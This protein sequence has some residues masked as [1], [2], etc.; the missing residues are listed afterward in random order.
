[1]E[2]KTCYFT[3]YAGGV[4]L[5]DAEKKSMEGFVEFKFGKGVP[6][7]K[8]LGQA[9]GFKLFSIIEHYL[10]DNNLWKVSDPYFD[11]EDEFDPSDMDLYGDD[12]GHLWVMK[13]Y[14]I[15]SEDDIPKFHSGE[16]KPIRTAKEWDGDVR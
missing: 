2:R 9:A 15:T 14:D 12:P 5:T 13:V 10:R 8:T 6:Y 11:N 7:T 4:K 3:V 1:M 16:L